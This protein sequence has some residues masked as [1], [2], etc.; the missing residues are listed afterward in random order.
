M[1]KQ[2]FYTGDTVE[3]KSGGI[4][5][6]IMGRPFFDMN[7]NTYICQWFS[8]KTYRQAVFPG[9]N[10]RLAAPAKAQKRKAKILWRKL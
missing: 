7:P 10:L 9:E 2:E 5:M 3:L 8:G 4:P 1:A 6:Q